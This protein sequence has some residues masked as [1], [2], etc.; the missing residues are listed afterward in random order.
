MKSCEAR[1][2][3][4]RKKKIYDPEDGTYYIEIERDSIVIFRTE[5]PY[6]D[7]NDSISWRN[8]LWKYAFIRSLEIWKK[9]SFNKLEA[10]LGGLTEE[11]RKSLSGKLG[12]NNGSLCIKGDLNEWKY[13]KFK[14][15]KKYNPINAFSESAIEICKQR[16]RDIAEKAR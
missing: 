7:E 9:L 11:A 4:C 1:L 5:N 2:K 12:A 16:A 3:V 15:Y 8:T 14:E 10:S 13:L 6:N